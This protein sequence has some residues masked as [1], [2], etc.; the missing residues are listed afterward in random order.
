MSY[1]RIDFLRTLMC[2]FNK[3]IYCHES[4]PAGTFLLPIPLEFIPKI[5]IELCQSEIRPTRS[6][7]MTPHTDSVNFPFNLRRIL[8]WSGCFSTTSEGIHTSS[9]ESAPHR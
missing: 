5:R 8:V 1:Q 7:Q 2:L 9:L 4:S 3:E 6:Q